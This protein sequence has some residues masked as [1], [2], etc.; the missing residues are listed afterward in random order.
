VPVLASD[1]GCIGEILDGGR[2]GGL[3]PPTVAGWTDAIR[4]AA[5]DPKQLI[6]RT[7][8]AADSIRDRY[9]VDA[10]VSAYERLLEELG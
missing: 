2:L 1:V 3:V 7:A 6:D 10:M 9:S 5:A 8:A 4:A